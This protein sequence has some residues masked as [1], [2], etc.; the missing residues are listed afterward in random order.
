[1]GAA[2]NTNPA[3]YTQPHT[4]DG[5]YRAYL[6][7]FF[8]PERL[9]LLDT[10]F[11]LFTFKG[12]ETKF[13]NILAIPRRLERTAALAWWV[14]SLYPDESVR[15]VLVG[16]AAMELLADGAYITADLDF[17]G[18]VPPPVAADLRKARFRQ[19]GRHWIHDEESVSVIFHGHK[20]R[21]GERTVEHS[22]GDYRV[23][24]VSPEDLL[25]DRLA[26][27][28]HRESPTHGVQAY[29]LYQARHGPMD[30]EHLRKRAITED[31]EPALDSVTRLFF[32]SKG[33]LPEAEHLGAWASRE[34]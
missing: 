13:N 9:S 6:P 19:L 18:I 16:G 8:V 11:N 3:V 22:F 26:S 12:M 28:R 7:A 21:T 5:F 23:F 32:K 31:V 34:M 25:I 14:Q 1:M 27:W 15:P 30:A 33:Q 20:L 10:A 4:T 24:M 2:G 29:L 17:V